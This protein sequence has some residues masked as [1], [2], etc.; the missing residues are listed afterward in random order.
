MASNSFGTMFRITTFGESHGPALGVVIDGCPAG[1]PLKEADFTPDLNRRRPGQSAV[2]TARDEADA[3]II[4]SGVFEGKTTGMPI[5]V[6]VQ[7]KAQRSEDYDKLRTVLRPGHADGT[8]QEK[9]GHRD[10]RGGGRQS[11][12]ETV[13]RVIAGVVAR[14]V[15]PKSM[16]IIGHTVKV[17]PHEAKV[18][19][20]ETI[21]QNPM[22][23]ADPAA[24]KKME[25]Y[26]LKLK[27]EYNSS[28]GLIEIRVIKPPKSLGDPVFAKLKARLA[29]AVMSIGAVHGFSYGA[30]FKTAEMKG[31][32]YIADKNVFGGILGGISTGEDIV[33]HVSVKP[34]TSVGEIAKKGRHDP[35]IVP[36][37]IPVVEAMV[38]LVLADCYLLQRAY[39]A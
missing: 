5:C 25:A 20:P 28:G 6:I 23:C 18:F 35:C 13:A 8:F 24:A 22:R 15:L 38:S 26:V 21:E 12:R 19:K 34:S 32:D 29:D 30:G 27:S 3:P 14:K 10:H 39:E 16:K 7:N 9:F 33:L 36:R 31:L 17:G 11:G 4:L 2:T 37:V 1:I